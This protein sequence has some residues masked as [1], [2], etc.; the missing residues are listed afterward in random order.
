[1]MYNNHFVDHHDTSIPSLMPQRSGPNSTMA[2]YDGGPSL[3]YI[4]D[5]MTTSSR[6]RGSYC[7][8]THAQARGSFFLRTGCVIFAFSFPIPDHTA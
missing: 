5:V 6:A 1:M 7:L 4:F 8:N 2:G 3:M